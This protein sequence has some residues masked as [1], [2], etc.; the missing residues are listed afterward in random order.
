M[1]IAVLAILTTIL[2]FYFDDFL[3]A[4]CNFKKSNHVFISASTICYKLSNFFVLSI[5]VRIKEE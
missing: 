4:Q 2:Y 5:Q 3:H 1:Q